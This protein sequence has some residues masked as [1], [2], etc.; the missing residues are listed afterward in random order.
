MLILY[1]DRLETNDMLPIQQLHTSAMRLA[2]IALDAK[3]H[4]DLIKANNIYRR[5]MLYERQAAEMLFGDLTQEPTRS[6][7]YR[8]AGSLALLCGDFREAERLACKG[9]S[10]HPPEE[11]AEEL[12]DVQDNATFHTHLNMQGRRL[13]QSELRMMM[14]GR[15]V[16]S[17]SNPSVMPPQEPQ[18]STIG[19]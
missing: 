11:I 5:A 16:G 8:S 3:K 4:G 1:F 19:S 13:S 15:S 12:R 14:T 6:V 17:V 9:L 7:L 10:G 2:D 18:R